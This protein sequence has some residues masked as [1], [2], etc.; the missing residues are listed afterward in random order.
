MAFLHVPKVSIKGVSA[1]VPGKILEN[2]KYSGF[3]NDESE[4]IIAATGIERHRIADKN[5]CTSDLCF[6]AA[7]K[8]VSDLNWIKSDIDCLVFVSQTPDYIIPAT[9]CLLQKRLGLKEEIFVLDISLGC[10]GWV[11]GLQVLGSLLSFGTLKKGLLLVG[12]T[13]LKFCS[14]EDK[15]TFPIFGDAGTA[16]A[17][18]YDDLNP[19]FNFHSATDGSNYEALMIPDGGFRNQVSEFSFKMDEIKP[20]ITRNRLNVIMEGLKILSFS[21]TK[22]PQSIKMLSEEFGIDLRMVDYFVLHQANKFINERIRNKLNLPVE[23]V[24]YSLKNYGNTGP[25]TIPLT[26]VT[27][28]RHDLRDNR[29]NIIACGFGVG[30]SWGSVQF[31]TDRIICPEII[32]I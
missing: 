26:M 29:R 1:C 25:G 17:L 30:L 22:A 11:Y 9:S 14:P 8:L 31:C 21:I 3:S 7:E 28:I 18:E 23:K 6:N 15:S 20:G 2:N 16:T 5:I 12:D 24:P 10:S 27:E 32:E 13:T 4:T 19:G